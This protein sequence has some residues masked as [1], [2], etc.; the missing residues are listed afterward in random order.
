VHGNVAFTFHHESSFPPASLDPRLRII[1][2]KGMSRRSWERKRTAWYGDTDRD[3]S[4]SLRKR[5]RTN[6]NDEEVDEEH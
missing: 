2:L 3:R 6:E 4:G 1:S 5:A